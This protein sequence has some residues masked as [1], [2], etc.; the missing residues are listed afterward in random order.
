[1]LGV[2]GEQ[3]RVADRVIMHVDMD[4]FFASVEQ[5]D[6]PSLRGKPVLVG[7]AGNRGV[8][9][10]A[11]YEA[12]VFGCHSAQPMI[13]ARRL[14]PDA[15]VVKPNGA[16]YREISSRVFEIL[17]GFTPLLQPLSVDEAFL[18]V[19]GSLRLLGEPREIAQRIKHDIKAQTGLNASVGVAPNKFLAKLASDL[20]KP[21]G[22]VVIERER[23]NEVLTPLPVTVI[24]GIGP[25]ARGRLERLGVR[26]IGDALGLPVETLEG[27]LGSFGRRVWEL[28]RGIDD[29]PVRTDHEAKSISHEQ[30]FGVNAADPEFVRAVIMTQAEDVARRLRRHGRTARTVTIKIRFGDFET[31]TRSATLPGATDRTD[32]VVVGG[33][34]ALRRVG[35]AVPPGEAHRCRGAAV[36]R[37]RRRAA[38]AVRSRHI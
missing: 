29:R 2:R 23:I 9:A 34:R 33:A 3:Y 37:P 15:A 12:R 38:W 8:V 14:C 25:A 27:R 21:D 22:L 5:F 19:T 16:R 36:E 24:F 6:D 30:T 7:G 32:E 35:S 17:G 18:D 26:T 4:A 28:A 13:V 10:A 31:V 1:M 20:E 11:S